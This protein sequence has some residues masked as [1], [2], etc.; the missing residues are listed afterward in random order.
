MSWVSQLTA[1]VVSNEVVSAHFLPSA[2][3]R[4]SACTYQ[5]SKSFRREP[6]KMMWRLVECGTPEHI[7]VGG[8]HYQQSFFPEQVA[9]ALKQSSR[10]RNMFKDLKHANHVKR[11]QHVFITLCWKMGA[12]AMCKR[13]LADAMRNCGR[14][15]LIT[16]CVKTSI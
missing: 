10:I 3:H 15:W 14:V 5:R 12:K 7:L 1:D 13:I 8:G 2:E 9:R 6:G 4:K 11:A 16:E